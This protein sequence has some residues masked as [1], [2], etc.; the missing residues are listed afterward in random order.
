MHIQNN[1]RD[2]T[3]IWKSISKGIKNDIFIT[4]KENKEAHGYGMQ[5]IKRIAKKYNGTMEV[6]Y[7]ETSFVNKVTLKV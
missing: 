2:S 3:L 7:D 6:E 4:T 1:R 5:I